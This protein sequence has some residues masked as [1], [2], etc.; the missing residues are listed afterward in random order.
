MEVERGKTYLLRIVNAVM[1]ESLFFAVAKHKLILVGTDGFYTKPFET[2][3]IMI[4]PGQSM[5]VLLQANQPPSSYYLAST[6]YSSAFGAGFDNTTATGII[7][8]HINPHHNNTPHPPSPLLPQ[9]PPHNSTRASTEFTRRLRSLVSKDHPIQVPTDVD[10][11]LL[12][13]VSVNLLNCTTAHPCTGPFSK[14]FSASLNNVSFIPPSTD[15][16]QAYY[17]KI[18]GVFETDFPRNPPKEFD[19]TGEN[20]PGDVLTPESGTRA[21]VLR[22]NASVEMVLQGTNVLASDNHPMHLHGYGFYVVGWGFGNFDRE[23]DPLRYN[24]VDPPQETTVGIPNNGWVA[25][26]LRAD[27]P[28]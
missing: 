15:I 6:A 8:Y 9:L 5:D 14:R 27:N 4:S 10:T 12:I 11:R 21:L 17:R 19:Y 7:H 24:L 20:L 26:R 18:H 3:Y 22:Y 1:D 25:I 13:T 16:L 23:K 28:G 2:N